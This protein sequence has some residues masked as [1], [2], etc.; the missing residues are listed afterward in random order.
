M[1]EEIQDLK[2]ANDPKGDVRRLS[3]ELKRVNAEREA[4]TPA[5]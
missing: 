2:S 1:A 5:F 4:G 3:D